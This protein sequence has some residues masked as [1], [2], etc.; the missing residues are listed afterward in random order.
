MDKPQK[1]SPDFPLFA[2]GNGQWAKKMKGKLRYFGPW[3][4]LAGALANFADTGRQTGVRP[5]VSEQSKLPRSPKPVKPH[6]DYPLYAHASGRWAK[7]IRGRIHYFGPWDDPQAAL[8]KYLEQRDDLLAGR[9]PREAGLTVELLCEQ[10]L[11]AKKA[12]VASHEL[13]QRSWDDYYD[14]CKQ[15]VKVIGRRAVEGLRPDDLE[16]LRQSFAKTH[17]PTALANDVGRSRVVFN[18]AYKQGLI[19]RPVRFGE[20]RKPSRATIRGE[21]QTESVGFGR[22]QSRQSV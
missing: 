3:D 10:F 18:Y 17:G 7:R 22:R 14:T 5:Q 13:T 12:K 2:H 16:R 1:P 8:E 9:T 6:K 11:D 19:D 4:D 21:R 15:I 20:F